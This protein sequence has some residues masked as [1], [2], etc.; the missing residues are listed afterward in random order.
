MAC[1]SDRSAAPRDMACSA[2]GAAKAWSCAA[3][4][5]IFVEI[6]ARPSLMLGTAAISAPMGTEPKL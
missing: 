4:S 1:R 2:D 6:L 3:K 5:I